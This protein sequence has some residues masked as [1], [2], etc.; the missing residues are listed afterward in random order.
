MPRP[1]GTTSRPAS[2]LAP[3]CLVSGWAAG[4]L[5]G[6]WAQQASPAE[7]FA[8][9]SRSVVVVLGRDDAGMP[10]RQ[11]SGVV[12]RRGVVATNCHVLDDYRRPAI[13]YH[14]DVWLAT[15]SNSDPARDICLLHV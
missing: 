1:S 14:G 8:V 5:S 15:R 6:A 3:L 7:V 2:L 10:V 9:A 11:G 13:R 12:I 4:S